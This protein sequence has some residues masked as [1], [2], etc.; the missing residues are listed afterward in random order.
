MTAAE[1]SLKNRFLKGMALSA[2]TV[3]VVTTAGVAGRAGVTVSAM[4]SVS[5]DGDAP[6]LLACI[7][8]RSPAAA[9]IIQNGCFCANV[10]KD[11][12]T[13]IADTFAG[14]INAGGDKFACA[15]WMPMA[16]GAPRLA[17]SLSAFDCIALSHEQ[18]GT[19]HIFIGEVREIVASPVGNP[20]IYAN[21][22]YGSPLRINSPPPRSGGRA[23]Y[24]IGVFHTFGPYLLPAVLRKVQNEIGVF[25]LH[26]YEGDQ[27]HLLEMLRADALDFA[28]LYDF[29]LGDHWEKHKIADL[30]PYV[31]LPANDELTAR[32]EIAAEELL[33]KRLILLDAPPS[34]DYFLSL[35][36]GVG[37]PTIACRSRSFEM[38][39]G[40]VAHGLGYS[41][42]STKPAS[43]M[44]YDGKALISRPLAGSPPASAVSLCHRPGVQNA[45]AECFLK[46]CAGQFA[47]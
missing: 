28:F 4:T 43:S 31:L 37:E 9:V 47:L 40:M 14:R 12:Q 5:A 19:H 24:R 34:G 23:R 22:A 33:S 10:L 35:F 42:L 17:D 45:D 41:L 29:D 27:R 18:V 7:H 1:E 30:T 8:H 39:R 32:R 16:S 44:S 21:R 2:S 25:D 20:L 11:D 6:T 15:D 38:V 46:H 13:H 36:D 26:L 3:N